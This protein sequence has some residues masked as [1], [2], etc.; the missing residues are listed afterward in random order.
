[1]ATLT[2]LSVAATDSIALPAGTEAQKPGSIVETF[3]AVGTTTWTAPAGVTSVEVLVVGGGGGG[4]LCYGG[5]GGGGGVVYNAA[6]AV[7]PASSYTVTVGDGGA[8]TSGGANGGNGGNSVFSSITAGGGG[9]G[10]AACGNAGSAGSASNGNGGGGSATGSGGA[11]SGSGNA[12]GNGGGGNGGGGGGGGAGGR[13][14]NSMPAQSSTIGA[15][16]TVWSGR[17]VGGNGGPG[18]GYAI[19]G[20]L[21]YYGGGGGAQGELPSRGG[22]GGGGDGM[23]GFPQL[24]NPGVDG[25]GGGGG[26]G[27][28]T[29]YGDTN[30]PSV[31]TASAKGGSGIVIIRYTPSSAVGVEVGQIRNNT[32][33]NVTE[34]YQTSGWTTLSGLP[35]NQIGRSREFAADSATQ[36]KAVTGTNVNGWYWLNPGGL[37]ARLFYCD[38]NYDGGGWVMVAA[39]RINTNGMNNL[40]YSNA[41]GPYVNVRG[42][43]PGDL[44]SSFN[45]WVGM[46]YWKYLGGFKTANKITICQMTATTAQHPS[47]TNSNRAQMNCDYVRYDGAFI[48]GGGYSSEVNGSGN[49]SGFYQSHFGGNPL[50]T[51]DYDQDSYGANCSQLY[52]NNPYWYGAC[53]SGNWFAGNGYADAYYWY[54]SG[55]DYYNYG[56]SYVK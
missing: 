56:A 40:T 20:K 53:W 26:G 41:M 10:G 45:M 13:G 16:P 55:S 49:T 2:S 18:I 1:M 30:S 24:G 46:A 37:G 6:L 11:G 33:Y 23:F 27:L 17:T 21:T 29:S 38:M 52:N 42:G 54:G 3:T 5:G 8:G 47:G 51:Y 36:I 44:L 15:G 7:T 31:A 9:A 48:G 34:V 22:I 28:Q 4:G 12:G 35:T 32:T 43:K 50:T 25:T 39:N 14:F 19:S